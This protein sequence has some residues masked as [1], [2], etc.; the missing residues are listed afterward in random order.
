MELYFSSKIGYDA[1]SDNWV[2]QSPLTSSYLTVSQQ[3]ALM[4]STINLPR[5]CR[6]SS[7][8]SEQHQIHCMDS[9][10]VNVRITSQ[11]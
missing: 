11:H 6:M 2:N 3:S 8:S 5:M 10:M 9:F 1:F 4:I 7:T